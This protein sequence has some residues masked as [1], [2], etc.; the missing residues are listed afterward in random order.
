MEATRSRAVLI[1]RKHLHSLLKR[2]RDT[3]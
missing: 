2:M 3:Y 1:L